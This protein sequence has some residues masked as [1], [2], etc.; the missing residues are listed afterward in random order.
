M[1]EVRSSL[2]S[3]MAC[4]FTFCLVSGL[5]FYCHEAQKVCTISSGVIQQPFSY[6]WLIS[7][8]QG[9]SSSE[10]PWTSRRQKLRKSAS[11]TKMRYGQQSI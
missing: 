4:V 6:H 9:V 7:L 3:W 2:G 5:L 10:V 1:K 11:K 8:V